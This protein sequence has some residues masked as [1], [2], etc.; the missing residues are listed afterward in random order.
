MKKSTFLVFFILGLLAPARA[1][2]QGNG[3]AALDVDSLVREAVSHNPSLEAARLDYRAASL[4]VKPAGALPD[5]MLEIG[6]M[7]LPLDTL[8]FSRED[9]TQKVIGVTQAF[10][11]PGKRRLAGAVAQS[12]AEATKLKVAVLEQRLAFEVKK[13]FLE[14]AFAEESMD[15]TRHT[16]DDIAQ[17]SEA[18]MAR[19]SVGAG[20][21]WDI[22]SAQVE[23][24][25]YDVKLSA[26]RQK[27]EGLKA[28]MAGLLGRDSPALSGMP[29][30]KWTPAMSLNEAAL[31]RR[32]DDHNPE[33]AY[34]KTMA[35]RAEDTAKLARRE[36]YP[37]FSVNISYGQRDNGAMN[38]ETVKRPDFVSAMVGVEAPI[39]AGRKQGPAAESAE[40]ASESVKKSLADRTLRLHAEIREKLA[41]IRRADEI[42]AL[43]RTGI[44]PQ[45]RTALSSAISGYRVGKVDFITLITSRENLLAHELDYY[46]VRIGREIN[47][48]YLAMLLGETPERVVAPQQ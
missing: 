37:N 23:R 24:S 4:M 45:A 16:M 46:E 33:I 31:I 1:F 10:P 41:A 3:N 2:A 8:S 9:M 34:L 26:L 21:Q 38:G 36:R 5:P 32:A 7:S 44:L 25:K 39:Y 43:Y 47:I 17:L 30:V 14:W 15:T 6:F 35:Q 22:L 40:S 28:T 19:Y 18:A 11:F 48:A 12:E 20:A 27:I 13:T 42:E 29:A